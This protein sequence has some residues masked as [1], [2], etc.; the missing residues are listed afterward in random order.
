MK[1]ILLLLPVFSALAGL[2]Q[3]FL[4]PNG[5]ANGAYLHRLNADGTH[6]HA[7]LN[8]TATQNFTEPIIRSAKFR[9]RDLPLPYT[10]TYCGNGWKMYN[11][12]WTELM[13]AFRQF[14]VACNGS[15]LG[16]AG[17]DVY[18]VNGTAIVFMCNYGGMW[19]K[20]DEFA[21][22]FDMIVDKCGV[23]KDGANTGKSLSVLLQLKSIWKVHA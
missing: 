21:A 6:T 14:H 4:V 22:V 1:A 18:V 23:S 3:A 2:S 20:L 12:N 15:L 5:T 10:T 19:C 9:Q 11:I 7:P 16:G 8:I 13:S 17:N